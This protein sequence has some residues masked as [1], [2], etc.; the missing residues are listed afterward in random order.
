[1]KASVGIQQVSSITRAWV[2]MNPKY[3]VDLQNL[4]NV[5]GKL[6]WRAYRALNNDWEEAKKYAP[7]ALV[8]ELGGFDIGSTGSV[9]DLMK[10][11]T[12]AQKVIDTVGSFPAFMDKV[13]WTSIWRA[14]KR[15]VAA[16][17]GAKVNDAFLE[18]HGKE[19]GERFTEVIHKTQ[20]YDSVFTRSEL[21]RSKSQYAQILMAFRGEPTKVLTMIWTDS[22]EARRLSKF[23]KKGKRNVIAKIGRLVGVLVI[24][25]AFNS[26]LKSL[27]LAGKDDD[28]DETW[29]EKYV[30]AFSSDFGSNV[31]ISGWLSLIPVVN[32]AVSLW[33]GYK[34]KRLEF[35]LL[36][37]FVYAVKAFDSDSKTEAEKWGGLAF[38]IAN[39]FGVPAENV[40]NDVRYIINTVDTI[41]NDETNTS[42]GIK[43]AFKEGWSGEETS[44]GQ[45]LYAAI[46]EGDDVYA[47]RIRT[48]FDSDAK[49]DTALSKALRENEP[50]IKA[51]AEAKHRGDM[52]RYTNIVDE[53]IEEGLFEKDVVVSA[54]TKEISSLDS[55]KESSNIKSETERDIQVSIYKPSDINAAFENGDNTFAKKIIDDL[56]KTKMSNGSTNAEARSSIRSSMTSYWKPLYLAADKDEKTRIRKILFASGLYGRVN[57][58]IKTC[59]EWERKQ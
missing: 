48:R 8:K 37:D 57:E 36:E 41:I 33:N 4:R 9:S 29:T 30:Q 44:D 3:F 11:Q 53:I 1:M 46:V 10:P 20:V 54:I 59:N 35:G 14:V 39:L 25:Q 21:M 18:K 43:E 38:A 31:S 47:K 32:E 27:I 58:V 45:L 5:K 49:A 55:R 2:E 22:L 17:Y 56:V 7:V 34:L 42:T 12:Q 19:C 15:E 52:Q 24:T 6:P 26:A 13:G 28:E 51:A 16:K 50:R 40:Y 23:D